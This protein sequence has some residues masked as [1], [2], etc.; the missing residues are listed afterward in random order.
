MVNLGKIAL[1]FKFFLNRDYRDY[2]RVRLLNAFDP[3]YFAGLLKKMG[4]HDLIEDFGAAEDPLWFYFLVSRQQ[5]SFIKV[6]PEKWTQLLD[7]SPLFDTYFY[8]AH[9]QDQ[10]GARHPFSHYLLEGWRSNLRP[11]PFFNPDYYRDRSEW[12]EESGNPLVHYL[13]NNIKREKDCSIFF[14]HGWYL[15]KTPLPEPLRQNAIKHYKLHGSLAGKSGVPLFDPNFYARQIEEQEGTCTDPLLHYLVVGEHLDIP[16][17]A[18]FDPGYYKAQCQSGQTDDSP[19][20][21]YLSKGVFGR[22]EINEEIASLTEKPIVSLIVPVYNPKPEFLNNC[23][24]SVLYQIYPYWELWLVDDCSTD[25]EIRTILAGWASRD[26]RIKCLFNDHNMGISATTQRGA[27]QA[28][29]GYLGFL[30]NDD[31]LAPDCLFQVVEEIN[32]GSAEVFYTDED[33]IGDDGSRHAVFYKPDFNRALLYSHN[34][35]THFVVVTRDLF[36]ASGGFNREYDGAQDYDLVLRLAGLASEVCHVPQILYHWRAVETSTSIEHDAKPYAHDAGKKA[37]QAVLNGGEPVIRVVDTALNYHYRL[38]ID[39]QEEPS[40]S[41]AVLGEGENE[42]VEGLEQSTDY[43]N[44]TFWSTSG[45]AVEKRSKDTMTIQDLLDCSSSEYLAIL[46]DGA[47]RITSDWLTELLSKSHLEDDIA[48]VCGRLSHAG[49]DG[50]S[51]ATPDLENQTV[52]Y[53]GSFLAFASRHASGLHNLQYV[54]GCDFD[55]C[56]IRRKDLNELGGFDFKH[57][58]RYL[59]MLD[60]C[61]RARD[62]GK[63]ILYTPD[64]V[65]TCAGTSNSST[66]EAPEAIQEKLIFQQR[67]R[68]QLNSFD[69]WYNLGHLSST[70]HSS[71]EFQ[72]WLTGTAG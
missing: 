57:F 62:R 35:I 53:F 8:L 48:I 39:L 27:E 14:S 70:K 2:R 40:V 28:A 58:P 26:R 12:S 45:A 6:T 13:S 59:P 18:H 67:H 66:G 56:L 17:S 49:D 20:A 50:P 65:V 68:E 63:K 32:N 72:R 64:A 7:P 69:R 11:S 15:D 24:R 3:D 46:G 44:C 5:L 71:D 47:D 1:V 9:Y 23:I 21:H 22:C 55:I 61:Y 34:F 43:T 4:R 54:N 29:G 16:P 30:D 37:L 33:L 52:A 60:L 38:R 19:L 25:D 36:M 41:V 51:Y 42:Q 10:I 31:E